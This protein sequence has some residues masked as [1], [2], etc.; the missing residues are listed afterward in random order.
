MHRKLD[1]SSFSP[2]SALADCGAT[3]I[4]LP[5]LFPRMD[6]AC[7]TVRLAYIW[8]LLIFV[9]INLAVAKSICQNV[10]E[11]LAFVLF[12]NWQRC[13][14]ENK[15][16]LFSYILSPQ[17]PLIYFPRANSFKIKFVEREKGK[18]R[19]QRGQKLFF[20]GAQNEQPFLII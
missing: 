10:E 6:V 2:G 19:M 11:R 16:F 4:N 9:K 17:P 20:F 15:I 13:C 8:F 1:A 3:E 18:E 14:D 7:A 12:C 5:Q